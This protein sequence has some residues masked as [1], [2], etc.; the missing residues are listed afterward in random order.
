MARRGGRLPA[1]KRILG[2]TK[3]SNRALR[4]IVVCS[5]LVCP[6]ALVVADPPWLEQ[7]LSVRNPFDHLAKKVGKGALDACGVTI[8][9]REISR[10]A[11]YADILHDPDPNRDAE[12]ARLGLLGRL[13]SML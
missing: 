10:D 4:S 3:G 12:R 8:I 11:Q 1:A 9:Q 2:P 13:A 5:F 6:F 7:A